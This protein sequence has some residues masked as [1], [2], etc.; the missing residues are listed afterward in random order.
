MV[1]GMWE[2]FIKLVEQNP[3]VVLEILGLDWDLEGSRR[4][5][6]EE[7]DDHR[8]VPALHWLDG[9]VMWRSVTI[10]GE[11]YNEYAL[12]FPYIAQDIPRVRCADV[13][14]TIERHS[15][16]PYLAFDPIEKQY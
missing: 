14:V 12:V 7:C 1:N 16:T 3:K 6:P 13:V 10:K 8:A 9:G 5:T 15:L 11:K 2:E 4:C